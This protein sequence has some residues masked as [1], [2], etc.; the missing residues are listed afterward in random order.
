MRYIL[1][2]CYNIIN[3]Y[4]KGW[5]FE[6]LSNNKFWGFDRLRFWWLIARSY[7]HVHQ[8]DLPLYKK[9]DTIYIKFKVQRNKYINY[10][11][12]YMYINICMYRCWK[13]SHVEWDMRSQCLHYLW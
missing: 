1:K 13:H 9:Y 2:H 5:M 7:G 4:I 6:T 12:E 3:S 10:L 8:H 11:F